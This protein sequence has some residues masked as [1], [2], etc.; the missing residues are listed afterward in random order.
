MRH[1]LP[2]QIRCW[3]EGSDRCYRLPGRMLRIAGLAGLVWVLAVSI[4]MPWILPQSP[5]PVAVAMGLF[6]ALVALVCL[7]VA[8]S[9]TEL[10]LGRGR[11][12]R[13]QALGPVQLGRMSW[14]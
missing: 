4:M 6:L 10:R 1:R 8:C 2:L 7:W 13:C 12:E 5:T 9:R 11:L 3:E 14:P